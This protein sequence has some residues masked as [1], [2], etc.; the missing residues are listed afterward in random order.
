MKKSLPIIIL[1]LYLFIQCKP[2]VEKLENSN[3]LLNSKD[4]LTKVQQEKLAEK[5]TNIPVNSPLFL[6]DSLVLKIIKEFNLPKDSVHINFASKKTLLFSPNK[7]VVV[8]PIVKPNI[9]N[10]LVFDLYVTLLN[11]KKGKII[12]SYK[13]DASSL[14]QGGEEIITNI[15]IIDDT[16]FKIHSK[17]FSF[18]ISL[19]YDGVS[20]GKKLYLLTQK[21]HS[22]VKIYDFLMEDKKTEMSYECD[23]K[24]P[25]NEITS[26][27]SISTKKTNGY[28]NLKYTTTSKNYIVNPEKCTYKE[29]IEKSFDIFKFS[30]KTNHYYGT[31]KKDN[32]KYSFKKTKEKAI[33]LPNNLQIKYPEYSL[34]KE[35]KNTHNL[36]V[37][38]DKKTDIIKINY[39]EPCDGYSFVYVNSFP[40]KGWINGRQLY[41]LN[42]DHN[43]IF[44]LKENSYIFTPTVSYS[45]THKAGKTNCLV[46]KLIVFQ[47]KNNAYEG[48]IRMVNNSL[49]SKKEFPYLTLKN[50]YRISDEIYQL[51]NEGETL[52]LKILRKKKYRR[53]LLTLKLFFKENAYY[54]EII[55]KKKLTKSEIKKLQ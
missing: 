17:E 32:I 33:I 14:D 10:V 43:L 28:F 48:L 22:L 11:T 37:K 6:K 12:S 31:F 8:L 53:T 26:N 7:T 46:N 51:E 1:I 49:Y 34:K 30:K 50:N 55:D 54:A 35:Y 40:I 39:K 5:S 52:L 19:S 42:N 2:N 18:G 13:Q 9:H 16:P 20:K 36:I 45:D 24:I 21:N 44:H 41:P 38:V 4:T 25:S 3:K 47:D 27:L 29:V 15:S 23:P